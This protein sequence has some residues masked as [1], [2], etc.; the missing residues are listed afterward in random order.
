MEMKL[1]V[2]D[3]RMRLFTNVVNPLDIRKRPT[4]YLR[5]SCQKKNIAQGTEPQV[6][7][8]YAQT[9]KP[10]EICSTGCRSY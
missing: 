2:K 4:R 6:K 9:L 3:L 7:K 8:D 1:S 10:N 5:M